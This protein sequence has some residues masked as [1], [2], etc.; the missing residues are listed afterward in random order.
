MSGELIRIWKEEI[1][2]SGTMPV[3]SWRHG[4]ELQ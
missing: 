3:F 2:F 4:R 1:V